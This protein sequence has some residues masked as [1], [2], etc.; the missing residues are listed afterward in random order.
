MQ[1]FVDVLKK[2][3][4][5]RLGRRADVRKIIAAK[6]YLETDNFAKIPDDYSLFI[7]YVNGVI[8]N[9]VKIYGVMPEVDMGFSDIVSKNEIIN[10]S[11]K[12]KVI[13]IGSNSFDWLVYDWEQN[14]YQAR[15]LDDGFV[16]ERFSNIQA[17]LVYFLS[18]DAA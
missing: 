6:Q 10:R 9:N 12:N 2:K 11:D 7:K 17:A 14:E 18:L 8:G 5:L 4:N 3:N 15:D 1:D 16:V 13:V